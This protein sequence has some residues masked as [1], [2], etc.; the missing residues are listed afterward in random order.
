[1][2]A[3]LK[4]RLT[5]GSTWTGIGVAVAGGAALPAPYSWLAIACGCVAIFCPQPGKAGGE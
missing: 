5:E 1:M 3:Y 2:L 4:K